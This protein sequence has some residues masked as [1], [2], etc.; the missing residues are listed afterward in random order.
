MKA[1]CATVVAIGSLI[2]SIAVAVGF[3]HDENFIVYADDQMLAEDVLAKANQFRYKLAKE[4]FGTE[5][6]QGAG[7]TVIHVRLSKDTDEG[8]TWPIDSA[9]RQLHKTWLTTSPE[10]AV[11][12]TL[13]HEILHGILS[14]RYPDHLPTLIEE[15]IAGQH[16][17]PERISGRREMTELFAQTQKWPDL[18]TMLEMERIHSDDQAAYAVAGSLVEYLLSRSDKATLLTFGVAGKSS[19]WDHAAHQCYQVRDLNDLEQSWHEWASRRTNA[20][21]QA[22]ITNPGAGI[23]Q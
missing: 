3:A 1:V 14:T 5:L 7:R 13:R 22:P 16:D 11:G 17:E 21:V 23:M 9:R 15:G 2:P 6:P 20:H 19:S 4:W 10:K 18:A 12:N 8:L